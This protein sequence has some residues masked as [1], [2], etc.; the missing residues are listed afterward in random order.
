MYTY[1]SWYLYM[2]YAAI[3]NNMQKGEIRGVICE[4]REGEKD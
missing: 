4:E 2:R 1:N 3:K